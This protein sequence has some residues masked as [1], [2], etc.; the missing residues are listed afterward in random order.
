MKECI[1][2]LDMQLHGRLYV[3]KHVLY[4]KRNTYIEIC[5][6]KNND[7]EMFLIK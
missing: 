3:G 2:T 5:I 6:Y 4:E 1:H 7:N